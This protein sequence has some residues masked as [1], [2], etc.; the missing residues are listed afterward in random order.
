M[1]SRLPG[2]GVRIEVRGQSC[3]SDGNDRPADPDQWWA[4]HNCLRGRFC[5]A[6]RSIQVVLDKSLPEI[7]CWE[8]ERFVMLP[9]EASCSAR[10][11]VQEHLSRS[12]RA[13]YGRAFFRRALGEEVVYSH[14]S[15]R[16]AIDSIRYVQS[17]LPR[18]ARGRH[19]GAPAN[20]NGSARA[21]RKVNREAMS[22]K[23]EILCSGEQPYLRPVYSLD[24]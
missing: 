10:T 2:D 20:A 9:A 13:V 3:T 12:Y 15:S 14:R 24:W 22:S 7:R 17:V 6:G 16:W 4:K 5:S 19:A 1:P 8:P 23:V 11:L 18:F 21:C